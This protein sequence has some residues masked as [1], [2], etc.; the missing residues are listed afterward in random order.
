MS[1][2]RRRARES[3]I[4]TPRSAG[5]SLFRSTLERA[6]RT[7]PEARNEVALLT[8]SIIAWGL[9]FLLHMTEG[10]ARFPT[11]P[12]GETGIVPIPD[13]V[14]I[15]LAADWGTGTDSA[16]AVGE[17]IAQEKP[18]ITIHMGD[19]YY[20]GD[21]QEFADYFLPR[22]CWPRGAI[23]TY[24]L[25][26]NHE[27]YSGGHAYFDFA[28]PALK[29][30]TSYFCLE[31]AHWR[32]IG[33]DTAYDCTTGLRFLIGQDHT[34]VRGD[35]LGWLQH[36]VFADPTDRRPVILLSHHQWFTAFGGH[37]YPDIGRQLQPYLDRVALW[38]W[39]HEHRFAGYALVAPPGG[40][41]VRARCIGHGGMP[42]EIGKDPETTVDE[43]LKPVFLDAR[44]HG[45][46]GKTPIGYC[47]FATLD[48]DGPSLTVRYYDETPTLLLEETWQQAP[49]GLTGSAQ[50]HVDA[51]D[52]KKAAYGFKLWRPIEDLTKW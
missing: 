24:A 51:I 6:R 15:G 50:L 28:L 22:D 12:D 3:V 9:N 41:P 42:V 52:G 43:S 30:R 46:V 36:T 25:P 2:R 32:I 4:G 23:G 14:R 38:F 21:H 47:G 19:V 5:I 35:V 16:Y 26:G 29:Q 33:I 39:G 40:T 45:F 37:G 44:E 48:L 34:T 27:M 31:N 20:S 10:R 11:Y 8:R 18:D 49:S 13:R 1:S 17:A 7:Y